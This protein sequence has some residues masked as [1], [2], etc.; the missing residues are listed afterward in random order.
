MVTAFRATSKDVR[1]IR[2]ARSNNEVVNVGIEI[3]AV[4]FHQIARERIETSYANWIELG[5][6]IETAKFGE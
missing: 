2:R 1:E 5:N 6:E 4:T 3:N